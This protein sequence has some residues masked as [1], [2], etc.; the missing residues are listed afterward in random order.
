MHRDLKSS[1]RVRLLF[2]YLATQLTAYITSPGSPP[3]R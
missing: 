2:D 1:R 3:A